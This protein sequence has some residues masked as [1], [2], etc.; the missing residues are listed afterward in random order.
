MLDQVMDNLLENALKYTPDG[1]AIDIGAEASALAVTI[2]VGDRGPGLEPGQDHRV[3]DKFSRGNMEAA[4]SGAGLGLSI[5]RAIVRAHGGDI[6]AKGRGGGG[7]VFR[8][9]IPIGEAPPQWSLDD[10]AP[11]AAA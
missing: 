7:V 4:Q 2:W 1:T 8:F 9:S 6:E 10:E 11:G 3:F 5:C